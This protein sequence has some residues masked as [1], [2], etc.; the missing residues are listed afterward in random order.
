MKNLDNSGII[1]GLACAVTVI[2]LSPGAGAT[3]GTES[4]LPLRWEYAQLR[5]QGDSIV[6]CQGTQESVVTPAS[7]RLPD[8]RTGR[9]PNSAQYVVK[10]T[11]KRNH[12]VA[13]LDVFGGERWE[14]ASVM[15]AGTEMVVLMKR[16]Y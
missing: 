5:I 3:T 2:A 11:N 15:S 14:V 13:A 1:I 8:R 9:G 4:N 12:M 7:S 10:R 16:P 6:F